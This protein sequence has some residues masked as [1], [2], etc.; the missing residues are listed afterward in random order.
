MLSIKSLLFFPFINFNLDI[1]KLFLL[2]SFFIISSTHLSLSL[3]H[4][5][6]FVSHVLLL[7][8][9]CKTSVP[10]LSS[11]IIIFFI[12]KKY[13]KITNFF[14]LMSKNESLKYLSFCDYTC[15]NHISLQFVV[16]VVP[17]ICSFFFI[18]ILFSI[19]KFF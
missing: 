11:F 19:L 9:F 18:S 10:I 6:S 7:E 13:I 17:F 4:H 16:F 2:F 15:S 3:K 12:I 8:F 1:L 5:K 14:F